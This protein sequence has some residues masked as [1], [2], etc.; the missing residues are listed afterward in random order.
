MIWFSGAFDP[1]T[2]ECTVQ[3]DNGRGDVVAEFTDRDP[4]VALRVA[5]DEA[6]WTPTVTIEPS[7]R[8]L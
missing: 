7:P 4:C 3:V 1:D 5:L 2:G 6:R 8:L